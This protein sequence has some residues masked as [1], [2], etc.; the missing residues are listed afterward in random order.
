MTVLAPA[1]DAALEAWA[2]LMH[3]G[4][5]EVPPPRAHP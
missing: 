1:V 4:W 5:L 2:E 3:R